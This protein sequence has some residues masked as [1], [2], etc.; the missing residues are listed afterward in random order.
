M[1]TRRLVTLV[2][3]LIASFSAGAGTKALN[4]T[5]LQTDEI[6]SEIYFGSNMGAGQTVDEH[7]WGEFVS[8]VVQVRFPAG[9]TIV[10]ALGKGTRSDGPLTPTRILIIVHPRGPGAEAR[11]KEIEME[12]KKRFGSAGIFHID[13]RVRVHSS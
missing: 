11:L 7:A 5:S 2:L 4:A 9:F 6:K 1:Q 3:L 12:Y 10:E 8:S 13:Q